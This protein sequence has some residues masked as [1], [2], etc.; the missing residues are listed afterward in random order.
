MT[1]RSTEL[2]PSTLACDKKGLL[3]AKKQ[4]YQAILS[5][6]KQPVICIWL[7][8]ATTQKGNVKMLAHFF[9]LQ[10]H[11]N[12]RHPVTKSIIFGYYYYY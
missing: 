9:K 8:F 11:F 10:L 2:R 6:R 1:W 5:K 12:P 7:F 3:E 4:K